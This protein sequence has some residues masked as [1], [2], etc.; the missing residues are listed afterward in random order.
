MDETEKKLNE[1]EDF[2]EQ[3]QM[4]FELEYRKNLALMHENK[5]LKDLKINLCEQ[6]EELCSYMEEKEQ[7]I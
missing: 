2:V 4:N 5:K 7:L 1:L 6:I 3:Q